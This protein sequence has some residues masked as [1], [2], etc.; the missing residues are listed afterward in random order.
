MAKDLIQSV[1]Q[2]YFDNF[3]QLPDDKQFHFVSRLSSWNS[4]EDAKSI[5]NSLS[6]RFITKDIKNDLK[7]LIDNPP[8]AKINAY[9]S[10]KQ[11]FDKYPKLRGYMMALFRVRHLLFHF[12]VDARDELLQI[13]PLSD[14]KKLSETLKQDTEALK[15]LSTYAINFI[16]LVDSILFPDD[17]SDLDS[18]LSTVISA[19]K[20][21]GTSPEDSLLKIYLFTHCIIGASNFYQTKV[22]TSEHPQYETMLDI[23]EE[24][25]DTNFKQINLDN[26]FEFLV[27]CKISDYKTGLGQ[28]ILDE[29]SQSLSPEGTFIIDT[30]NEHKQSDKTSFEDAEHRN[31]LFIMSQSDFLK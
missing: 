2:Y 14:L 20:T 19:S 7:E 29:A 27:C 25:I 12:N 26:K 30:I 6:D 1:R 28:R 9:E 3:D 21:Y 13:V 23:M 15:V 31:V 17:K 4:D 5:I 22:S 16:Y 18:F 24:L 11:F 8:H 10:R